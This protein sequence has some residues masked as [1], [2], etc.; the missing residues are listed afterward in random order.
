MNFKEYIVTNRKKKHEEILTDICVE[1]HNCTDCYNEDSKCCI[2]NAVNKMTE[3][4]DIST[5]GFYMQP[6]DAKTILRLCKIAGKH[7]YRFEI[8]L[9]HKRILLHF[10]KNKNET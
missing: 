4:L 9:R 2:C 7:G 3:L 10:F 6:Y 1:I 5:K 8:V